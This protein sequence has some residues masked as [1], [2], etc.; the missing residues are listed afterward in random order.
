MYGDKC[1]EFACGYW[2][3]A[4]IVV[5]T[6]QVSFEIKWTKRSLELTEVI[7]SE[8]FPP[9]RIPCLWA[10]VLRL[11]FVW[12]TRKFWGEVKWNGSSRWKFSGKK[13]IPFEVLPFPVFAETTEVFCTICLDYYW[14]AS[15]REKGKNLL[16]FYRWYNSIL[17]L[18]S[19]P[20]NTST[21]WR[22]FFTEIS[23]HMIS[24]RNLTLG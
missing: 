22:K 10:D 20:K 16:V 21:I 2:G 17:F 5:R 7:W 13:V 24:A 15:C 8:A 23:V 6:S 4:W 14:Q 12:K 3:F 11:P 19:E 9:P 1:G 18:F